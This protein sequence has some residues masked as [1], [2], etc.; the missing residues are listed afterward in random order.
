MQMTITIPDAVVTELVAAITEYNA[1][2]PEQGVP[3]DGKAMILR[4]VKGYVKNFI[5]SNKSE[6]LR[7]DTDT[8]LATLAN[9]LGE[10]LPP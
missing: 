5:L 6:S 1:R 3:L 7:T 9:H 4:Q 8:A 2:H 10:L